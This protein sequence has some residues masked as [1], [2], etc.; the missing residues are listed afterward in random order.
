MRAVPVK[1]F[2]V[3]GQVQ[4]LLVYARV[5]IVYMQSVFVSRENGE[6]LESWWNFCT[7][8]EDLLL[9][10]ETPFR[11]G[12]LYMSATPFSAEK[13]AQAQVRANAIREATAAE[14][15]ELARTLV[16]TDDSDP[17]SA[18]EFKVRDLALHCRQG[19]PTATGAKKN[20]Y[21]GSSV[22]CP[23]C[24]QAAGFHGHRQHTPT[25]ASAPSITRGPTIRV[26]VAARPVPLRP[27]G[28]TERT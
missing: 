24:G 17:H 3:G 6:R 21:A 10:W 13:R 23:H 9:P 4:P 7:Q 14:I 18:S 19:H 16:A 25:S 26:A 22:T 15:D 28:R 2:W 1:G 5:L 11:H 12:G 27:S 20:G 8:S